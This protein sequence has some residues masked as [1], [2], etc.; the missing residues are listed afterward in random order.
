MGAEI[1]GVVSSQLWI[2]VACAAED[3][4]ISEEACEVSRETIPF[5]VM[6]VAE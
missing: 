2:R 6:V 5:K 3:R 1:L 4:Y